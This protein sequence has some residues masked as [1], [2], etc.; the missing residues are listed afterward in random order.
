MSKK[1][2]VPR[3]TKQK[4]SCITNNEAFLFLFFFFFFLIS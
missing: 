3:K 2:T 4:E 1:L